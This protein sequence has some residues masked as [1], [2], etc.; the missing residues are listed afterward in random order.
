M[1][2]HNRRIKYRNDIKP[3]QDEFARY[4]SLKDDIA[5]LEKNYQ[6]LKA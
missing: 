2:L 3:V 6:E 5:G 4:K 1:G